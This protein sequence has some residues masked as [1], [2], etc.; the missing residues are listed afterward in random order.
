MSNAEQGEINKARELISLAWALLIE[1]VC[2]LH[3]PADVKG[4]RATEA[5]PIEWIGDDTGD[6]YVI[7]FD[8]NP[9]KVQLLLDEHTTWAERI[10]HRLISE[11]AGE[12]A[13]V[14]IYALSE[15]M[16]ATHIMRQPSSAR[17]HFETFCGN[18]MGRAWAQLPIG[19]NRAFIVTEGPKILRETLKK[20]SQ[21]S[22]HSHSLGDRKPDEALKRNL[23]EYLEVVTGLLQGIVFFPEQ[24]EALT[25]TEQ[26]IQFALMHETEPLE[27]RAAFTELAHSIKTPKE[28]V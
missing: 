9:A 25:D 23:C 24:I 16:L 11:K 26:V 28:A 18:T 8:A 21:A 6:S 19:D 10:A 5:A 22:D 7:A 2:G 4:I 15:A 20:I 13:G 12:P 17:T 3:G 27:R 14:A 1:F